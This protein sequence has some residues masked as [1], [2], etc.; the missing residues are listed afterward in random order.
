MMR[1]TQIVATKRHKS[2]KKFQQSIFLLFV[3]F[4]GYLTKYLS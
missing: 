1:S 2:R 4:C 3:P